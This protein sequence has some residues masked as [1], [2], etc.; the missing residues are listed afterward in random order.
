MEMK[1]AI[2]VNTKCFCGAQRGGGGGGGGA[3]TVKACGRG[4]VQKLGDS[5]SGGTGKNGK[6]FGTIASLRN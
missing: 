3:A 5:Q 6:K 1:P 2:I 4:E